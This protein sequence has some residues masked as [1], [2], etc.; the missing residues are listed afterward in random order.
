MGKEKDKKKKKHEYNYFKEFEQISHIAVRAAKK[1]KEVLSNYK[2]E[3]LPSQLLE[4][5][6]IEHEADELKH[7][8]MKHLYRDFLPPIERTDIIELSHTLDDMVDSIE[9]VLLR[10]DMFQIQ[11]PNE[12]I[13]A[14][15]DLILQMTEAVAHVMSD[16]ENFKK[17]KSLM[18]NI[19]E[20]N[21]LEEKG[22]A[23]YMSS[24]KALFIA[25]GDPLVVYGNNIILSK[26]E[27]VC[28][29]CETAANCV[30][31]VILKNS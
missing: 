16:F 2:A 6:K 19:I 18:N 20:V 12:N 17:S 26:L 28:D 10:F 13:L 15:T 21:N 23:L 4:M 24:V 25:K 7:E 8:M 11:T 22:D 14:F 31:G 5:H 27:K 9:D 29:S 1:L 30:E 3:D